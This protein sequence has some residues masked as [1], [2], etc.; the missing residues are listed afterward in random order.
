MQSPSFVSFNRL[1][2]TSLQIVLAF[3]CCLALFASLA[4]IS[5]PRHASARPASIRATTTAMSLSVTQPTSSN[6]QSIYVSIYHIHSVNAQWCVSNIS[7]LGA[8]ANFPD[9]SISVEGYSGQNCQGTSY[10]P[11]PWTNFNWYG[12][13][14]SCTAD[15][16]ANQIDGPGCFSGTANL[17]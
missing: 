4:L 5:A 2:R 14:N 15:F 3:G 13:A 7:N 12:T 6:I 8:V 10:G 11:L 9:L 1:W 17:N 16:P